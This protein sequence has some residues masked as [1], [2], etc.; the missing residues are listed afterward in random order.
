MESKNFLRSITQIVNLSLKAHIGKAYPDLD[1]AQVQVQNPPP[2]Q[3]NKLD[4]V[5]PAIM[6]LYNKNK[7]TIP[8]EIKT[9][10]DFGAKLISTFQSDEVISS[11]TLDEKNFLQIVLQDSFVEKEV[12]NMLTS[13]LVMQPPEKPNTIAID[14]SSPNIAKE[15][16]VGHLR[17][18]IIGESICRILEYQGHKTHRINHIGDWGTQF[19]MLISY[20]QEQF[21]DYLT[22]SPDL[23][24]LTSFYQQAKVSLSGE[25]KR[26]GSE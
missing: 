11:L 4:F 7:K 16:H 19:G 8:A 2:A 22:K 20:L 15:L 6:Q 10:A 5:S 17:S 1:L 14:F 24:S 13:N 18:S 23:K 21:P 9:P 25:R 12:N 26:L 3:Q